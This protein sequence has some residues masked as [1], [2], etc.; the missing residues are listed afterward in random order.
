MSDEPVTHGTGGTEP[1]DV[2]LRPVM[3]FG[4]GLIVLMVVV[5]LVIM[6]MFR[7]FSRDAAREDIQAGTTQARVSTDE[8][9]P[10]EPRI[11]VD[12]AADLR[13][14]RAEEDAVLHEYAWIDRAHGVVR[15]P[16]DMAMQMVLNEGLPIRRPP[17]VPPASGAPAG[18]TKSA[19]TI[20][21]AP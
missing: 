21:K 17:Q 6:A 2:K 18:Q 1:S 8:R 5:Y 15:V 4:I 10:P 11:Q 14:M 7:V 9:L 12:P 16:I 13:R 20:R 19:G 3:V